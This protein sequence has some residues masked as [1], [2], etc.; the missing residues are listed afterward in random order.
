MAS[1]EEENNDINDDDE[2]VSIYSDL[3]G[4]QKQSF[5][6]NSKRFYQKRLL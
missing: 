2:E 3:A 4:T 5:F 6:L 1:Q